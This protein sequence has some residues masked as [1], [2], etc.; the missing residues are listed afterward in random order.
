MCNTLLPLISSSFTKFQTWIPS[1]SAFLQLLSPKMW[2]AIPATSKASATVAAFILY[3]L[4]QLAT[5]QH[6]LS[7]SIWQ[8]LVPLIW[9]F[10]DTVC[11]L[12]MEAVQ[13]TP[14]RRTLASSPNALVAFS[15]STLL[16]GRQEGH[17]ARK[18]Y[19]GWWRWVLVSPDRV[20]PSRMVSQCV[21][22][23]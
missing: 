18:K 20:S 15:A 6:H 10:F 1:L 5:H 16:V 19:G 13:V 12:G 17:S 14:L 8:L 3:H 11:I 4:S 21:C 7:V 9:D 2:N 23:C 22:L